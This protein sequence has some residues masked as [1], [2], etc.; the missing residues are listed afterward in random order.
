MVAK[1]RHFWDYA[2]YANMA[3]SFGV[4]MIAGTLLGL[5]GGGWLDRRLGTS[6]LFLLAGVLLGIGVGFRS[7]LSELRV[8]EK[9]AP[10]IK[11]D[12]QDKTHPD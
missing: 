5:Y 10:G 1:K 2:R 12:A 9:E 3:F 6:P 11:T 8:L 4:T 7:V